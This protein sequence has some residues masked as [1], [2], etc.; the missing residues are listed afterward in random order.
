MSTQD[1]CEKARQELNEAKQR[2]Q[3]HQ[4]NPLGW[5]DSST[6]DSAEKSR[7]EL[8]KLQTE[9]SQKEKAL[10]DCETSKQK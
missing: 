4:S 7:Q 1:P 6:E 3:N 2:L 8:S 9:V 5:G 10:Q